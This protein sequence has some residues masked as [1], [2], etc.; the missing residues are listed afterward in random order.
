MVI[1]K[2]FKI[3]ILLIFFITF[4]IVFAQ[5]IL[6]C[7]EIVKLTVESINNKSTEKLESHLSENFKIVGRSGAKAKKVLKQLFVVLDENIKSFKEIK[8]NKEGE[9][10]TLIYDIE[11]GK[12]GKKNSVFTFNSKNEL[13]ELSLF[14]MKIKTLGKTKVE[15]NNSDVI[16]IPFMIFNK[17]IA[18]DVML[19][20][21][22]RTFILDSGSPR[23]ILNSKYVVQM[24]SASKRLSSA[25]GVSGNISGMD[26]Y[27]ID[28]LNWAGIQLKNQKIITLDISHLED[29][30]KSGEIY[31]LIGFDLIKEYDILYDY[32]KLELTLISPRYYEKF[33]QE[34]F[35]YKKTTN[36]PF[37]LS[38][39]IPIVE[40]RIADKILKYGI[41]CGAEI[42]LID[43]DLL[44]ELKKSLEN[45]TEADL[46]GADDKPQ[47]VI[48]GEI[49]LTN[50]GGK[51]FKNLS[52]VFSN[53]SHLNNGYKLDLDGLI[54]YEVLSKQK[55]L[56][57]YAKKEMIFIE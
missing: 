47:K 31:G 26:M 19:N 17:F 29:S 51:K 32:E 3:Q 48:K 10:L 36:V 23:V 27:R 34:N 16:K 35:Q 44:D 9:Q 7:R 46:I 38:K 39:H 43:E 6:K 25:K 55:T 5:D 40:A 53:I 15:K 8:S 50:I 54:G 4:Q 14:K 41:D 30:L 56:I 12:I 57:S 33:R 45:I 42:N 20:G 24:D 22:K 13:D 18:V 21:I 28:S 37:E 11:Y 1:M 2:K 49:P 52:T